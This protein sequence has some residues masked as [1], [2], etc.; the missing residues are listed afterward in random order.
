[1]KFY[2]LIACDVPGGRLYVQLVDS[3]IDYPR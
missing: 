2:D 1:M 3:A